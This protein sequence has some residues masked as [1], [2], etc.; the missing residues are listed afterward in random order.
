VIFS[1][2]YQLNR[3]FAARFRI[4]DAF[5]TDFRIWIADF[6]FKEFYHFN[7]WIERSDTANPKSEI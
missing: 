3:P 2:L 5:Q 1:I 4:D 6:G 7:K